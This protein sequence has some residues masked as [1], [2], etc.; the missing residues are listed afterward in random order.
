MERNQFH[1]EKSIMVASTAVTAGGT[2]K[3]LEKYVTDLVARGIY[4]RI[5]WLT[6]SHGMENGQ[7]GMNSLKCLSDAIQQRNRKSQKRTFYT[8]WCNFFSLPEEGEDPREY[9]PTTGQVT[10]IRNVANPDWA[11]RKPGLVPNLFKNMKREI[12]GLEIQIVDI[13][14]YHGKPQEL[15]EVVKKFQPSTLIIDSCFT[16][17]G[18]TLHSSAAHSWRLHKPDHFGK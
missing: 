17:G 9:D 2:K 11:A 6:G 16:R 13:A 18:Y 5:A 4:T 7:D 1:I 8:R 15:I 12:S 14:Y 3:Y 10:G